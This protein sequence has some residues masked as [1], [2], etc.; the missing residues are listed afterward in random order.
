MQYLQASVEVMSDR[1]FFL[2]LPSS[3]DTSWLWIAPDLL[4][5]YENSMF[6]VRSNNNFI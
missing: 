3:V 5:A 2:F 4:L 6:V 1:V